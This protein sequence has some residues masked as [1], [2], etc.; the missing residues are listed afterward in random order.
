MAIEPEGWHI[1]ASPPSWSWDA[2]ATAFSFFLHKPGH[3]RVLC[4]LSIDAI[5]M[6]FSRA[7]FPDRRSLEYSMRTGR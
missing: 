3:Q 7:S 6:P 1:D 5:E 4:I 2:D